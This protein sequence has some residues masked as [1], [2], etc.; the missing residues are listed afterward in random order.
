MKNASPSDDPAMNYQSDRRIAKLCLAV[1]SL[2]YCPWHG[3]LQ[4]RLSLCRIKAH[5]RFRNQCENLRYEGS[6]PEGTRT[7]EMTERRGLPLDA[8]HGQFSAH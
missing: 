5:Q 6:A 1:L 2:G 7:H 4:V 3:K 8:V